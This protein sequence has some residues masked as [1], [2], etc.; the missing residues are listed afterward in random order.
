M[1]KTMKEIIKTLTNIKL[2]L[3][4]YDRQTN[5]NSYHIML[6]RQFQ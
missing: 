5:V 6:N 3:S 1:T 2:K 4:I